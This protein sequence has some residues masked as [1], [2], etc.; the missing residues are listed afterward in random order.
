MVRDQLA[1]VHS[2]SSEKQKTSQQNVALLRAGRLFQQKWCARRVFCSLF[3]FRR[4]S[5][6]GAAAACVAFD[7]YGVLCIVYLC[8]LF[9][10][11]HWTRSTRPTLRKSFS[12]SC[13]CEK[14]SFAMG[15]CVCVFL[16]RSLHFVFRLVWLKTRLLKE[17]RSNIA[18]QRCDDD[19]EGEKKVNGT[20]CVALKYF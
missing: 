16:F 4:F 14:E 12:H 2:K 11:E 20:V 7:L 8:D 3:F 17:I 15:F 10:S 9:S 13:A 6:L 19:D 5:S 1:A 18:A